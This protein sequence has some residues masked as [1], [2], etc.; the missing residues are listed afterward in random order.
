MLFAPQLTAA[1][2]FLVFAIA[3]ATGSAL[4]A[5]IGGAGGGAAVLAAAWL[6]PEIAGD[7]RLLV[8]RRGMGAVFLLAAGVIAMRVF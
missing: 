5:G 4:P 2:R 3:V 6:A 7:S 8:A 1:A